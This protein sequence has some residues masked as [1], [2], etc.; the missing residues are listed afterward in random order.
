MEGP[1]AEEGS[2]RENHLRASS[3]GQRRL[4][5]EHKREQQRMQEGHQTKLDS[6]EGSSQGE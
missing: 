2:V 1:H 6:D 5:R 4:E 3:Q